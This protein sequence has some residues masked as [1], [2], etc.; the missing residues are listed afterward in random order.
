M[1]AVPTPLTATLTDSL[2]RRILMLDGGMGTMLQNAALSEEDFRGER[3][4]DWPSELKGNNDLLALTCPELVTRIHR[5][6]LEA[7]ADIVETNTFNSTRLSQSDYGM[8]ALVPELNR[9]S[10][11]LA[12]AVCDAVAEE[13]GVPRYVA[14]VLG[15]TSR[16]ASLSPDVN[17]PAKRN[18]TFDELRDNYREAAEALIAGGSGLILI[19][20]IFDTLN[21]KAAIYALEELFEDRGERLPVMISGTITDASGRTLSGQ[22]TEAFWNSIRH[23][24]PLSVGL[25]CALGA[26]ELRPYLKELAEKADTFVSAHPNAGLPNEFGEYDQTPEEM[27]AIVAEFARSGLVNIIGGCCGSTPEHIAA[28]HRAIQG[29]APRELP[30]RSLA[31]RL[32]GLEPFNIEHDSLFVNVGERTN[33]TGSARFKRLIKEED[34]TTA[35]E[36]AL[37]QVEN[38]AQ[39][40][41]VNMDEGML[42]SEEAM[43]RFLNLIAGEPDIARVPIM[44]D[45]SKWEI[46]E[47]GLK[48]IQ[49][50]AVVNSI[51][52]KEG[53]AAFR[54]Q[55]TKCRR[56]GAAVV[57]M[58]FDE[59]GQADTFARKTEIC[60]RAYRLLVDEIG[61]PPEDIIFDPNIFAIATGI[62]EHDNYAVDFIEATRWIREHLPHAMV[63]GGVSNVSFSFRGNNPVRE[64]IH[65][66][67]LYHAIRAGLTMGIVNAGQLAVYDDL[68][69][70]LREAVEDVVLNRRGDSTERLLDLADKYKGDGSGGARKEDLEWRSW[71]VE[72]RIEHALVKGITAYIEED[73]EL[74]R[75]RAARPI[76][77]IEGPLMDGMNV[78][79]DLFG[80]G[81][82]FLPQVVKSARVMKQAVA[83]LIPFI[84]AEKSADTQAK[85]KIVMATVKGDVHDI[86]KNIVGVVLQC[87]NYEVIDLGVMV[88]AERILQTA[89]EENADIIGLSGLITP[90][91]DEMVHVAKE[92]QRQGFEIPLLIGGATTSKAH[93]AVKIEPGYEHPVIYV[94]DASRAVGVAGKLLSPGLKEAYVA[95]IRA[96]YE[97]V[98]ERNAKRRPKAAEMSYA[99]ARRH[100]PAL[101]WDAYTPPRPAMTGLE[102]FDD[103][104]LQALV[105]RIDWTPFFMSWQLAGK[106]PAILDDAKVGEAAR[107]LFADAQAMLARLIDE[108]LIQARGVIGLWPAN[109]VDDDVIEVYADESRTEVIERLHHIRQ[110]TAKNR[111]GVCYSLA[112]F[113]APRD[114]G[115]PDWI[116]GFAVTTGHGVE[117][118]AERY[119]AAGDDYNAIMVQALADRLAEAFAEHMHERVRKEF[120]GYAADEA[121]DNEALIAEKYQGIRPAPGY[122]AC[123]DH[124]EK[125]TLFRLLDAEANAGLELTESFAMW[126]AAAVSGWYFAHPRSK[127]FSTGKITR[128]QVEALAERK[129]MSLEELERWLMPVLSYDPS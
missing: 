36:V 50:K 115:K 57:V 25:N 21:A 81:K 12:R 34:Y 92:M 15:P 46:L 8:E 7:G 41:D 60:Q 55:A 110:Q 45:S 33:V 53:E 87:N 3:F 11:R 102:V 111:E 48:C 98:R 63:S 32:S 47:A 61:F 122:P 127:Y 77:V 109:T 104:D 96:E 73:T 37:E 99:E 14:G 79:G 35:L 117:A 27:A 58:A 84:E 16:T 119:K 80:A 128:D 64:A 59:Q 91:L 124:T 67:F 125:A 18:V 112:D 13:T 113:V 40:I 66:V 49:G 52:L 28:I 103:Y 121:L 24:R 69:E 6:Y 22:T 62:E 70:E 20:T 65:S 23:A 10:A 1:A 9:E 71:E 106:Y 116:G 76:E 51:S 93:T 39:V 42:E 74:A 89:K 118:L 94:T 38:G 78:V 86:G 30:E 72:K 126:P 129:G 31:C 54:E 44:V 68:P 26:E 114:S 2:R 120:W 4:A 17:D 108:R 105:E 107:H 123:P 88:P 43:V 19:E 56:F 85:G 75:R 83:Y 82:M 97:T 95:E 90:S 100:K 101:D 5:D 29:L